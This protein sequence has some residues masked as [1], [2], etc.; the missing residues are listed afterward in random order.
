MLL[1]GRPSLQMEVLFQKSSETMQT[2]MQVER[3]PI[4]TTRPYLDIITLKLQLPPLH[5]HL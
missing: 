3:L 1:Q 4:P 2:T 5:R